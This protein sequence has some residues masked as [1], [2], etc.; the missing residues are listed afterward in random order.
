[1]NWAQVKGFDWDAGNARKSAD[2]H[3]VSMAED[4]Q[5]FFNQPLLLLA[6]TRHSRH[7]PRFHALGITDDGRKLHISFTL[8]ASGTLIRV[9]SARDMLRKER[10]VY[11]QA[12]KDRA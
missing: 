8:R 7:E 4:E 6:D 12:S 2:K 1:M 5:I 3:G 10:D 9:I 11:E